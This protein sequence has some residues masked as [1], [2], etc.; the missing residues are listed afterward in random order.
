MKE[1]KIFGLVSIVLFSGALGISSIINKSK[2]H[3]TQQVSLAADLYNKGVGR[4]DGK[5]DHNEW[6]NVYKEFGLHYD[7]HMSDPLTDLTKK[8]KKQYLADHPI[9]SAPLT[10]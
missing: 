5:T 1:L 3:L 9:D 6:T 2:I 10:P 8:Q 7:I 4:R